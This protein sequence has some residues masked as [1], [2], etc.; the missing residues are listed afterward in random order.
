MEIEKENHYLVSLP[1]YKY[2]HEEIQSSL[3]QFEKAKEWA[4]LIK[5]LQRLG[6]VLSKYEGFAL[7]PHKSLLAKRLAQCL[8]PALPSG[9]HLKTLEIYQQIFSKIQKVLA[10]DLPIYSSGLFPFFQF[11]STNVKPKVLELFEQYYLALGY[12]IVPCLSGLILSILPG[13]E[14]ETSEHY[15]RVMQLMDHI[16]S[17][18][19]STLFYRS[20][21]N[22]ILV[23]SNARLPAFTYL[24]ERVPKN[25]DSKD[26]ETILPE[27]NWIVIRALQACLHDDS[28][29]LVQR[30]AL[31]LLSFL[32]PMHFT[33]FDDKELS[34]LIMSALSVINRRDMSLN[35]R[36]FSWLLGNGEQDDYFIRYSKNTTVLAIK[37][38][39]QKSLD[40][41]S[42][43]STYH[44]VMTLLDKEEIGSLIIDEILLDIL[45]VLSLHRHNSYSTKIAK[46]ANLLFD[47]LEPHTLWSFLQNRLNGE[48]SS[49]SNLSNILDLID[50]VLD[51]LALTEVETQTNY[52]PTLLQT[53]L[54]GL[55]TIQERG[56]KN[57]IQCIQ[58][59]RRIVGKLTIDL[60]ESIH[61]N[62]VGVVRD[63]EHHCFSFYIS[64]FEDLLQ[65]YVKNQKPSQKVI[66]FVQNG[67]LDNQNSQLYL[68][69]VSLKLLVLLVTHF[70]FNDPTFQTLS[71]APQW[72]NLVYQ[73]CK[74]EDENVACLG[75]STFLTFCRQ[76]VQTKQSKKI[77]KYIM[78]EGEMIR[79]VIRKL[80]GLLDPQFKNVHFET[81][82]L[83]YQ[84][85]T[86]IS[87]DLLSE[88]VAESMSHSSSQIRILS[89]LRF[90]LLWRLTNSNETFHQT[91]G[92]EEK[93]EPLLFSNSLFGMMNSLTDRNPNIQLIG[94]I[95]ACD[96]L[97]HPKRI[98]DPLFSVL[99]NPSTS[100]VNGEYQ[101]MYDVRQIIHV[102][103]LMEM[104][105]QSWLDDSPNIH[106]LLDIPVSDGISVLNQSH[107][108]HSVVSKDQSKTSYLDLL[109]RTALRFLSGTVPD[110]FPKSFKEENNS[111]QSASAHFLK[112]LLQITDSR[113]G[114]IICRFIQR[115]LVIHLAESVSFVNL[116]LQVKLLELLKVVLISQSRYQNQ[117]QS[118]TDDLGD[119]DFLEESN[120]VD[121][122]DSRT[123]LM[124]TIVVGLL[125]PV[126]KPIRFYWLNLI[127][128][129]LS[130]FQKLFGGIDGILTSLVKCLCS[131][132]ET[133]YSN[134]SQFLHDSSS[135]KDVLMLLKALKSILTFAQL[136]TPS[137]ESPFFSQPI[138]IDSSSNEGWSLTNIIRAFQDNSSEH[139]SHTD[140]IPE[141]SKSIVKELPNIIGSI[142]KLW[143]HERYQEEKTKTFLE[144]RNRLDIEELATQIID[145]FV[146]RCPLALFNSM[147]SHWMDGST[148]K[149][150]T[151]SSF[152]LSSP[153][154]SVARSSQQEVLLDFICTLNSMNPGVFLSSASLI[155]SNLHRLPTYVTQ[156]KQKPQGE[157]QIKSDEMFRERCLF[158]FVEQYL[159]ECP[160]KKEEFSSGWVSLLEFVKESLYSS[161]AYMVL[162]T[163]KI[164]NLFLHRSN[165]LEDRRI[166]KDFQEYFL[167]LL[168]SCF[169]IASRGFVT[170]ATSDTQQ[171]QNVDHAT[172][173]RDEENSSP[174]DITESMQKTLPNVRAI[175]IL[176]HTLMFMLDSLFEEKSDKV[177]NVLS[178]ALQCIQSH[179]KDKNPSHFLV[180]IASVSLFSS[181]SESETFMKTWKKTVS[182]VFYD[183]DFFLMSTEAI[184]GW[185]KIVNSWMSKD[186]SA[187]PEL[188]KNVV[189][190]SNV[191]TTL[192]VNREIDIMNKSRN[193]KRLAFTIYSGDQDQYLAF[194]PSIQERLIEALKFPSAPHLYAQAFLCFKILV[195]KYS[196]NNLRT[197]WP[198]FVSEMLR[199]FSEGFISPEN[200]SLSMAVCKFLDQMSAYP[201]EDFNLLQ[202]IFTF[203]YSSE[204]GESSFKPFVESLFNPSKLSGVPSL[205]QEERRPAAIDD[206]LMVKN[207][208]LYLR[209]FGEMSSTDLQPNAQGFVDGVA[210]D[211]FVN[212]QKNM[213]KPKH[214]NQTEKRILSSVESIIEKELIEY[215]EPA[216]LLLGQ[217][218]F[219]QLKRSVFVQE[220]PQVE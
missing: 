169:L 14:D 70:R 56:T 55:K 104:I 10:V 26:L 84:L 188:L 156:W 210:I 47:Q 216:L 30:S 96:S 32:V 183:N 154:L 194:I 166:K 212:L 117:L 90:S 199:A 200:E 191:Q 38:L 174:N 103:G 59:C 142:L 83:L 155:L 196:P 163:L 62:D 92:E 78:N 36:L 48:L 133:D 15:E 157:L 52:L 20:L 208:F 72:L 106:G 114:A 6:K 1:K 68:L 50:P 125:Q 45:Y 23:S 27:K 44:L 219:I 98:L 111:V 192:F 94:R 110:S 41:S 21:W 49:Q 118:I 141:I 170:K 43:I 63:K 124:Q 203:D 112:F 193:M 201:S 197:L 181:I 139:Q 2:Y 54:Q 16:R 93:T 123:T 126:S 60:N 12:E 153:S 202:W 69:D 182:D 95:W 11:A 71:E 162:F 122:T 187:F 77:R 140:R 80:W 18:V 9:V 179:V 206:N 74:M 159:L 152:S 180:N 158:E 128:S 61:A 186:K 82:N 161:Q 115:H 108:A 172:N 207:P 173:N 81:A 129:C 176:S 131:I 214:S 89:Y 165:P 121:V 147:L 76:D 105:L 33:F 86:N 25:S 175:G 215:S 57:V 51:I 66:Y 53:L 130:S 3:E 144:K 148:L 113:K 39:F 34:M 107:E 24:M 143:I 100:R 13:L 37:Q 145:P 4:D 97:S 178:S 213:K 5:C 8:N 7:I 209:T 73:L 88:I 136:S 177:A 87:S 220:V 167:K 189:L 134:P 195:L 138:S 42:V 120:N 64:F 109:V 28:N 85:E 211:W 171:D 17:V 19:G 101:K 137:A 204:Q 22:G 40:E 150:S 185:M 217:P 35:R 146:L 29:V 102:W 65:S 184:K 190:R 164:V 79:D 205:L 67:Y 116:E 99:L 218:N 132:F 160:H 31:D 168:D 151:P 135:V 91:E 58:L 119:F 149:N 75:I 46:T 198:S 127:T